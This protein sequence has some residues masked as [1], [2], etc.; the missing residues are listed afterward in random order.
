MAAST[1]INKATAPLVITPGLFDYVLKHTNE[2][3]VLTK[4]REETLANPNLNAVRI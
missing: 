4:C 3:P 1:Q 2:H